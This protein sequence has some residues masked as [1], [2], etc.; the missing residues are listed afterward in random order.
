[1]AAQEQVVVHSHSDKGALPLKC[2]WI[3]QC[4]DRFP[5]TVSIVCGILVPLLSLIA[6]SILCGYALSRIE[7]P[8]EIEFNN[9]QL[10]IGAKL[11]FQL[12]IIS[13]LTALT[14][15]ICWL[16][17]LQQRQNNTDT[18]LLLLLQ[19]NGMN[20]ESSTTAPIE[21]ALA[22]VE[23]LQSWLHDGNLYDQELLSVN[24]T[25]MYDF[26]IE[27]GNGLK[28]IAD[29]L[30]NAMTAASAAEDLAPSP[31]TFNWNQ[32]TPYND[33]NSSTIPMNETY[34]VSLRPVRSSSCAKWAMR[35]F[36]YNRYMRQ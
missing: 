12:D 27:C 35:A 36:A 2:R 18:Q 20:T 26:M 13:N 11:Q 29:D 30:T 25:D 10:S 31:L 22:V 17:N 24:A 4:S 5:R 33:N 1:M 23:E 9:A 15:R 14:P 19:S 7:S 6:V 21:T 28:G 3:D 16:F 8:Y 34:T 32:C